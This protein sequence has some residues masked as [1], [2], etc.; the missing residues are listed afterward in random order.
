M[1]RRLIFPMITIFFVTMNVLLWRSEFSEE[2]DAGTP[3]PVEIVWQKILTAPDDSTLE[4]YQSG[5]KTGHCRWV[6]NVGE[7]VAT[8][9]IAPDDSQPEGMVKELKGYEVDLEGN[10][11]VAAPTTRL[12]FTAHVDF[13]TNMTWQKFNAKIGVRPNSLEVSSS[14]ASDLVRF[15]VDSDGQ[16]IDRRISYEELRDPQK[17]LEGF[18]IPLLPGILPPLTTPGVKAPKLSF[19][20]QWQAS[21]SWMKMGHSQVRVYRLQ[22]RLLQGYQ[23]TVIVSRVGEILRVELPFDI[24]LV[25]DAISHF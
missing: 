22:A 19:A 25:N 7:A 9:K 24:L 2:R 18:G 4:I 23:V 14:A 6:A 5:K 3:I 15:K 8:G 1:L 11:I 16:I 10:F 21:N 12:R 20:Q 17:F 13:T